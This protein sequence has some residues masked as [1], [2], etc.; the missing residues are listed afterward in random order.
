[1][2][3]CCT[4]C[5][6]FYGEK[7]KPKSFLEIQTQVFCWFLLI[8]FGLTDFVWVRQIFMVCQTECLTLF[9]LTF[10][11][12]APKN[13]CVSV[14]YLL[15]IHDHVLVPA[16]KIGN[17]V[18]LKKNKHNFWSKWT[19]GDFNVFIHRTI[20][21]FRHKFISIFHIYL[22]FLSGILSFKSKIVSCLESKKNNLAVP[23]LG[24]TN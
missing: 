21:P 14:N 24:S 4:D 1:M 12:S 18:L 20:V 5:A 19:S 6:D 17:S 9:F 3:M 10:G 11:K 2:K 8:L 22:L 23:I 16:H 13:K 7:I 15:F